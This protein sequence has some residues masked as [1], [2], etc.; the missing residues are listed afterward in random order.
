MYSDP[1]ELAMKLMKVFVDSV[2]NGY[3]DRTKKAAKERDAVQSKALIGINALK[4]AGVDLS[5][6]EYESWWRMVNPENFF[7]NVFT[8]DFKE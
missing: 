5:G 1:K 3:K 4:I 7:S 6:T 8:Y 2:E